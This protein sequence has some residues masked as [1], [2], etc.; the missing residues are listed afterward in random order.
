M[1][2]TQPHKALEAT[3]VRN[4]FSFLAVLNTHASQLFS[5]VFLQVSNLQGVWVR[6]DGNQILQTSQLVLPD[7]VPPHPGQEAQQATGFLKAGI[8]YTLKQNQLL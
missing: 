3:Y 6:W 2:V 5:M 1:F 4:K 7:R 8:Y